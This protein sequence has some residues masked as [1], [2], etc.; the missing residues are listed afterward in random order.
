M[1]LA[2]AVRRFVVLV[3]L[4]T[5]AVTSAAE[6]DVAVVGRVV[7][8]LR[9]PSGAVVPGGR[10]EVESLEPGLRESARAD[11][12]GRYVV[13][14]LPPGRYRLSA[15][16]PGLGT[17]TRDDVVVEA[18]RDATADL[19]L[20]L[21]T[22]TESVV[23]TAPAMAQPLLVETDPRQPRQPIPAHDG[24]DYLKTIPGFSI[25]RKGGTDGDPVLRGMAGS[26][27]GILLDGQQILGG[28]GG[29]MDPPTAYVFPAAYDR[30]TVRKGPQTVRFGADASAGTVLFERDVR[31]AERP[32]FRLD[33]ALTVSRYGRHDQMFDVRA[34]NRTGYLQAIG[35]RSH[36][37]DY[38]D[39][40]GASVHS[41]Y[42]RWS[43]NAA[44]G[45][46]PG[47]RTRVEL[48]A[49]RSDGEAAY[50]DRAMDAVRFARDNV[51]LSF[52]SRDV[53]SWIDRVEAQAYYNYIDHVMDNFTLRTPG[54][55]FSTMNPDRRTVGGRAAVTLSV[56]APTQVVLG[57]DL[58]QNVHRGRSG[59]GR[60]SAELATAAYLAAPRV[61]DMRF[62]QLGV[63]AE[64]T[65]E[66]SAR[67]R[68]IGGFR[69]DWHEAVDRRE[70]IG[71]SMCPGASPARN[72]TRGASDRETLPSGFGRLE[73]DLAGGAT[74]YAGVGHA[75]RFPDYW[76]RLVRDENTSK[77]D[78]LSLRPEKTTQLDVG[79]LWSSAAWS[80]SVSGFYGKVSDYILIRWAPAPSV[81]RNVDATTMGFEADLARRFGRGLRTHA[82]VA[83]VRSENDSDGKPLAQQP[84]LEARLGLDYE[85][86]AFSL[87]ALAR[88]VATQDRVDVG[89]GNIVVNG[90]DIGPTDGFTVLSINGGY[91]FK[92]LL[93][94]WGIDNLL[95]KTYAEHLSRGGASIPGYGQTTRV[96]EPGRTFWVKTSFALR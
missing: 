78:F 1:P 39:G 27:V 56:A 15:V 83:Y 26:R 42:T 31:R 82:T 43:A 3:A 25:I 33:S 54:T 4:G 80:G 84:P 79:A 36:T 11:R 44:L 72:D 75:E 59:P 95:G 74:L 64:T 37:D 40:S 2:K 96:N 67:S 70:C 89:S 29:R 8:T 51:A 28:C 69:M 47:E 94:T 63:F 22:R 21:P 34:A 93:A 86:G 17:A 18:G 19:D 88:L 53:L 38:R 57:G 9:D 52:E 68:L 62:D 45:W 58:R 73:I 6:P 50:A 7:G 12:E 90:M 49:A 48:S 65:H 55:V 5:V 14:S 81:A 60:T 41:V 24:G 76:E 66:L 77:S 46:T 20:D 71:T 30:I 35:T 92:G 13:R 23:V 87:G 32:E 16:A 85:R 10:L 61:E 91:R